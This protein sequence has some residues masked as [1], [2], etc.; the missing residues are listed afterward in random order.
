MLRPVATVLQA[1][2]NL[3]EKKDV[4]P[5]EQLLP[6]EQHVPAPEMEHL[7]TLK[8]CTDAAGSKPA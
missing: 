5:P 7:L 6:P 1:F 2:V 8:R 4:L 3:F